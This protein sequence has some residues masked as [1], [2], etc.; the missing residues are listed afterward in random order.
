MVIK[1]K[2]TPLSFSDCKMFPSKNGFKKPV[3]LNTM[4][5]IITHFPDCGLILFKTLPRSSVFRYAAA[6]PIRTSNRSLIVGAE[7]LQSIYFIVS[8]TYGTN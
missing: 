2:F 3:A 8:L 6:L 5:E 7:N 1:I 4:I